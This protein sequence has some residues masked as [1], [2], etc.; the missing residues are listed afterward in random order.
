M[1]LKIS[2]S[3]RPKAFAHIREIEDLAKSFSV[4][5]SKDLPETEIKQKPNKNTLKYAI[6]TLPPLPIEIQIM[7][8]VIGLFLAG[9]SLPLIFAGGVWILIPGFVFGF[10][11]AYMGLVV[12]V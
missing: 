12:K 8:G 11:L 9:I 2:K 1:T 7:F 3:K 5:K 4:K 10:W 6:S